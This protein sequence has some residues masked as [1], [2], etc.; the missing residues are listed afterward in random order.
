MR[1]RSSHRWSAAVVMV[2]LALLYA[3]AAVALVATLVPAAAA[4]TASPPAAA[5]RYKLQLRRA[6]QTEWG[7]DAPIAAMAA[8]VHQESAW[9]P[10]AVSR[11]GARGLS[12]FMPAT[13]RWWCERTGTSIADCLPH[14]PAWA[15][16]ALVGYDKWLFDRAPAHLGRFDRYW[17]A[18]RAYNGGEGHLRAEAIKT[19]APAPTRSQID[20]ACGQARRAMVHCREN[21]GYPRR[22]LQDI[23][24]R[25]ASWGPVMEP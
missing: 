16:R 20:A 3:I 18:L 7:L 15:L 4:Q 17:M 13:A 1:N 6:A 8:Q 5:A 19:G 14:N 11:V 21:L 9:N 22:I 10:Q 24:P 25:Y 12:Q 23:Q 2:V